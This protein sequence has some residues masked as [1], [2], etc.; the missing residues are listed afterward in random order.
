[1]HEFLSR[2]LHFGG[3]RKTA[4]VAESFG[5]NLQSRSSLLALVFAAIHHANH[6]LHQPKIEA[7][8]GGNLLRGMRLFDVVFENGI[9]NLIGRQRVAVFLIGTQ[10][11]GRRL[12]QA[13][14]RNDRAA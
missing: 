3:D 13:G 12:F 14:L 10:L 4:S 8:V 6:A 7:T 5:G 1:M 11:G 2:Y 9:E